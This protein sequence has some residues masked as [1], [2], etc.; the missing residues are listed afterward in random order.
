MDSQESMECIKEKNLLHL[1]L[2][3]SLILA[4]INDIDEGIQLCLDSAMQTAAMQSGIVFLYDRTKKKIIHCAHCGLDDNLLESVIHFGA[5]SDTD[6]APNTFNDHQCPHNI[7]KAM[8]KRFHGSVTLSI[9]NND[10]LLGCMNLAS[11]TTKSIPLTVRMHLKTIAA[12]MGNAISR[13]LEHQELLKSQAQMN[14]ILKSATGFAVY[15]FA[16][17][18]AR[19]YNL[20]K[21]QISP[22]IEQILGHKLDQW[23]VEDYFDNIH[24]E[25]REMVMKAHETALI[26]NKFE[27]VAR[28]YNHAKK[29]YVWIQAI[30][31]PVLNKKGDVTHVN[32]ILVDVN[33]K[34]E[35]LLEV[36]RKEKNLQQKNEKLKQLNTTLNTLLE[37]RDRD[38]LELE[39]SLTLNIKE[40]VLPYV[41][42]IRNV[43][44]AAKRSRLLDVVEMSLNDISS[45]FAHSLST[46]QL[47]LTPAEIKI[48]AFVKQGKSTKEIAELSGSSEKTVK[49]Q[50]LSIRKKIGINNKKVNL[51]TYLQSLC[52]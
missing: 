35:A 50:R 30:S 17:D 45:R 2:S 18:P 23:S 13:V 38:R 14:S 15:R 27:A 28:V 16:I 52:F 34:Q 9:F 11:K 6:D 43:G 26:T 48:A 7:C 41:E 4:T 19:K 51:R 33:E 46:A 42:Q 36:R 29:K 1:Q 25:D 3:L 22:S 47:G 10:K 5:F 24:P 44:S 39:Q 31:V 37:K 12:S 32:G 40:M 20:R 21:V 8:S 49:N